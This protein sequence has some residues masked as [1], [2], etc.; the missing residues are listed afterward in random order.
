LFNYE[1]QLDQSLTGKE[2]NI[3]VAALNVM[4]NVTSRATLLTLSDVPSK[5]Y[6]APTVDYLETT[7]GSIKVNFL[8]QNSDDG[9]SPITIVELFMDDGRQGEFKRVLVTISTT[10]SYTMSVERGLIYRFKFR[11]ANVN[12]WSDFSE[13]GYM[14]SFA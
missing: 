12:G 6:P 7:T 14:Y 4:G 5:P 13:I 9:G 2:I 11:T 8:N 10:T 1:V 3:K